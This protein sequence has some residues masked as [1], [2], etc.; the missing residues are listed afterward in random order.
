M[1]NTTKKA[2]AYSLLAHVKTSGTLSDG[3]MDIFIPLVKKGLHFMN[4]NKGQYKGESIAEIRKIIEEH[5]SI[6]IPIPVL[7]SILKK[8]ANDINKEEKIFELYQDNGFWIKDY[9]FEDFDEHIEKSKKEIFVLQDMFKEFCKINNV[10]YNENSCIIKFI[11]K[12]KASISYYLANT[13][14]SNG[15]DFTVAASFVDYFRKYPQIYAQ[16]RNLYLGS[17]LTCYLGYEPVNANMEV[18]LLLDTNFIVSLLDLNTEESTHTCNKL[19][20]ICL[21][22]GYKFKVLKDTIEE[23][24]ALLAFKSNNYDKEVITK[25]INRE[26]IYN[27]CERKKLN[28]VDLDRISDNLESTLLEKSVITI[29]NTDKLRNKA[30]ISKE[31]SILK[32]YRNTD[33]AALHDAMALIYVKN[34]RGK[35]TRDFE[36]INCWFVNN[37]ISHDIDNEGIDALLNSEDNGFQPEVIK[38]DDLL[39]ILWLSKPSVNL[40]LAN[41][42]LVDMGLTS[43]VA[44][45]LNESLPKARIIKELDENIQKYRKTN[46]SDRDVLLLATR[47]ANRQVQ[48]VE[49]LNDLAKKDSDKFADKIKE[50]ARKQEALE[51]ERAAKFDKLFK[52]LSDRI[53][54]LGERRKRVEENLTVQ[55]DEEVKQ[56]TI[57][58][59]KIIDE[60]DRKIAQL[61]KENIQIEN[62]RR[63]KL[64]DDYINKELSIWRRK[65]WIW[66][67]VCLFIFIAAIIW[68]ILECRGNFSEVDSK[69]KEFSQNSIIAGGLTIFMF[70]INSFVTK[71]LYDR[72]HNYSNIENYKRSIEIPDEYKLLTENE[73]L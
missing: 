47:I 55:K 73:L 2:I 34:L 38:A 49:N 27:A 52:D 58:S 30:K 16:I 1:D 72:Y 3:P 19:L 28:S 26:D 31:Y 11:E 25:Y 43:L 63:K 17:I 48:N 18:T 42:D 33:K 24:R 41:N 60:K 13:K 62:K 29:P 32:K 7:K 15:N 61:K 54:E 71:A 46:F 10:E 56:K 44:F 40:E 6:D 59:Q 37:A 36:K 51:K 64:S 57:E 14:K 66:A 70:I 39:N 45:T 12:N 4:I 22:L 21:K 69:I 35:R 67:G 68:L 8:I 9:V 65:A 53:V 20:D 50:E 5:Y 23:T